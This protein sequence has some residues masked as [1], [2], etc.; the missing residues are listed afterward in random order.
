MLAMRT[1][2]AERFQLVVSRA[3]RDVDVYHMVMARPDGR[4]GAGLRQLTRLAERRIVD[5]RR[6]PVYGCRSNSVSS[7]NRRAC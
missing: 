7:S 1:L 3:T 2:L 5:E 6:A 4:P